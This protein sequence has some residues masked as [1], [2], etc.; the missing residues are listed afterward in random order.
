MRED[1]KIDYVELPAEDM[2]AQT[3]FYGA[4]FGWTFQAYGPN[5][6]AFDQG[7]DGG[8]LQSGRRESEEAPA[9]GALR[10]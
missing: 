8:L 9:G 6:Q 7:L 4:A 2:A 5:Y 1:G 10:P 3:A